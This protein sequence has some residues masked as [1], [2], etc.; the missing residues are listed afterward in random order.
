MEW[1]PPS[2]ERIRARGGSGADGTAHDFEAARP[3]VG[4]AA[5][6][7]G[8]GGG[9]ARDLP[10]AGPGLPAGPVEPPMGAR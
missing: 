1:G 4:R 2:A 7:K 8:K 9:A 5:S 3:V 6:G 10:A